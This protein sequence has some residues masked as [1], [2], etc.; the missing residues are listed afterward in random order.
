MTPDFRIRPLELGDM[1]LWEPL[2]RDYLSFYNANLSDDQL[3]RE[4]LSQNSLVLRLLDVSG[5]CLGQQHPEVDLV[6]ELQAT[7]DIE[8]DSCMKVEELP[9]VEHLQA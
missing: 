8:L 2:W 5:A 7:E 3:V 1:A 6:G 4:R 9:R